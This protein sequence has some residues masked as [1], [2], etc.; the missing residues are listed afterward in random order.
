[1][2]TLNS[3][4]QIQFP[5]QRGFVLIVALVL[6]LV[7]TILGLAAAQS[8]SL[9]ERM[10]GNARNRDL[11][12]QAAEAGLRAAESCLNTG[13]SICTSFSNNAGGTYEFDPNNPPA[14]STQ[15][16]PLWEVNGFWSNPAYVLNYTT[17]TGSSLPDVVTQPEVIIEQLPAIAAPGGNI[18]QQQFGGGSPNIQNYRITAFGTGGDSTATAMLQ[19]IN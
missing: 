6:L 3:S 15:T 17:I 9:E 1:M 19:V 8:T 7:L 5:A 10:A 13:M 16:T 18:G 14:P 2:N 11:A 4:A 12:F